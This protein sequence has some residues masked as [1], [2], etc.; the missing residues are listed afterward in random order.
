MTKENNFE[1]ATAY[2]VDRYSQCEVL[3][4][5]ICK[6]S[7]EIN[8]LVERLLNSNQK[9]WMFAGYLSEIIKDMEKEV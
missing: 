3:Q 4:V 5:E 8:L 7:G 2:L 9:G 1:K 6:G